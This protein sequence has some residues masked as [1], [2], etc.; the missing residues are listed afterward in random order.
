MFNVL[1]RRTMKNSV[2]LYLLALLSFCLHST[3]LA[4]NT[5]EQNWILPVVGQVPVLPPRLPEGI[6][7]FPGA[8]GEVC[9]RQEVAAGKSFKS[10][11]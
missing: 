3:T 7:A 8:W 11:I 6:P 5:D 4:E 2:F 10:L 1:K 9:L